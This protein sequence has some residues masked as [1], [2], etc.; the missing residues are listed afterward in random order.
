MGSI[1]DTD[2]IL[3]EDAFR[4]AVAD[5]ETLA[6]DLDKLRSRIDGMLQNLQ[7]GFNTDAG[8]KFIASCKGNLLQPMEDQK[9]V[10]DH[11]SDTLK[12]VQGTYQ[13]VFE[14]YEK[15]NQTIQSYQQ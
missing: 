3:D 4:T 6:G 14:A 2:I 10:I 5:F 7:E 1:F 13:S 11:I 15:L 9:A 12:E 8:R